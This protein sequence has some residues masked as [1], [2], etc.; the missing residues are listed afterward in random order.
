MKDDTISRQAAIDAFD[1]P[2]YNI[3]GRENAERVVE[4]LKAVIQRIKDLPSAQP[5]LT[6]EEKR[7]VK[8]LRSYHNGSYAKVLDKLL[9]VASAQQEEVIPH[10]NYKYF[11]DYW[12]EC[13]WHLGKKGDVNYCSNCG[14][15]VNWE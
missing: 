14:R 9:A 13:G 15:K 3:T 12:C 10:R 11:S 4:Y 1:L 7:L 5:E 8:K 6:D 2:I